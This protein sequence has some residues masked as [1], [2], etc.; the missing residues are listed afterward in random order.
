MYHFTEKKYCSIDP[1]KSYLLVADIGGTNSTFGVLEYN[2]HKKPVLDIA[3][4]L[5]SKE[6]KNITDVVCN[7]LSLLKQ[8]YDLDFN[9]LCIG[10]AGVVNDT[11]T[12]VKPTNLSF[13]I[14]KHEIKSA[15]GL[16]EVLLI[17]DFQTVGYGIDV[18]PEKSFEC[19]YTGILQ[20]NGTRAAIG[21]GTGLGKSIMIWDEGDLTYR[22]LASEGGHGDF[23]AQDRNDL[24]LI[25]YIREHE[26]IESA[27]S[28]EDIISGHGIQ[29]IY[30]FLGAQNHYNST[31]VTVCIKNNGDHPDIIFY[32]WQVD[33]QC[34]DTFHWYAKL[35]ARAIKNFAL[36]SLSLGGIFV[37]GGIATQNINLFYLDIFLKEFFNCSKQRDLLKQIPIVVV[38]NYHVNLYGAAVYMAREMK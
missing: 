25:E 23:S 14:D 26:D 7:V 4:H 5:P 22:P 21:A 1:H 38:T 13:S 24:A 9:S 2:G 35:Y 29:R 28:W 31:E 6:I 11:H 15:T 10:A 33:P 8:E 30:N 12:R 34:Y 3:I 20:L 36:D 17:N 37:A 18:L 32:A 27:I 16:R 19:I